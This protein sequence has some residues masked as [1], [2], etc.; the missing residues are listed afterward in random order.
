[1]DNEISGSGNQYDYGFRIY[2]PR[3]GRFL[4]VDPLTQ[5]YPWYT[6]YQFAGNKPIWAVDLDGLEEVRFQ[7]L[8]VGGYRTKIAVQTETLIAT[9][10]MGPVQRY[11]ND[12][13]VAIR[14]WWDQWV[15]KDV[16]TYTDL[17]DAS[18]LVV[19]KHVDG[20]EADDLDKGLAL[21]FA[22]FVPGGGHKIGTKT[23]EKV[24]LKVLKAR[25]LSEAVVKSIVG[26]G[27]LRGALKIAK[28]A[29]DIAHHIIPVE[30]L[31]KNKVVQDAVDAGFGF[32]SATNGFIIDKSL[33][34]SHD[35]YNKYVLENIENWKKG[36]KD[37]SPE[38]AREYMQNKLIPELEKML[39]KVKEN[40][41]NLNEAFK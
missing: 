24:T 27:A 32:N 10:S 28:G 3:I 26:R 6:P 20:E 2:N 41:V 30:A 34:G 33:H 29:T 25:G 31:A 4:S 38:K 17:D 18:V 40:K 5:S 11:F 15:G 16:L 19:G 1:M 7:Y 39:D 21:A 12:K 9:E 22:G 23:V 36:V 14:N 8:N 13:K 37:Y 35:A